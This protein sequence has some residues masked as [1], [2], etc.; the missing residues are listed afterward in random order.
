MLIIDNA[1]D[2]KKEEEKNNSLYS[3]RPDIIIHKRNSPLGLDN[4]LVAE[5]K[6]VPVDES[7][8]SFDRAKIRWNTCRNSLLQYENGLV[9]HLSKN[10]AQIEQCN[11]QGI[12]KKIAFVKKFGL[13]V[14]ILNEL[15]KR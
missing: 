1:E 8:D 4:Y 9:V 12:F 10:S 5:F 3:I 15:S 11:N 7:D 13:K 2:F 14:K 6:K